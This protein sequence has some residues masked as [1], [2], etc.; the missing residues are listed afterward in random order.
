MKNLFIASDGSATA[1]ASTLR[2]ELGYVGLVNF[3][4]GG[5]SPSF[6]AQECIRVRET[7]AEA[8]K[9]ARSDASNLV[10]M[11]TERVKLGGEDDTP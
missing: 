11:W 10:R 7:P 6:V 4:V 2:H 3:A 8:L 1:C 5:P 9:D